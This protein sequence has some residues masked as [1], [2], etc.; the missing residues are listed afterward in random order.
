MN[1]LMIIFLV[2]NIIYL[3]SGGLILAFALLS[4]RQL[5]SSPTK[6]NVAQTLLLGQ[7]PL[8]GMPSQQ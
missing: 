3:L 8:T 1:K 5:H 7:C 2:V 6:S 4:K